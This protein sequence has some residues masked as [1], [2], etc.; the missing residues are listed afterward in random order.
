MIFTFTF[1]ELAHLRAKID[2]V[3]ERPDVQQYRQTEIA[4]LRELRDNTASVQAGLDY[5]TELPAK[6][7][8]H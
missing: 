8:T 3:V 7:H 1:K 2:S 4:K 5:A 6:L